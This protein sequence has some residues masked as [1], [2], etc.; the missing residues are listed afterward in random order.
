MGERTKKGSRV[1]EER[2]E[3]GVEESA[4]FTVK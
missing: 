1:G 2:G 4:A 3:V